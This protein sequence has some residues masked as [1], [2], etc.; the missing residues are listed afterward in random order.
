M[1]FANMS[2]NILHTLKLWCVAWPFIKSN[3]QFPTC[4]KQKI[5]LGQLSNVLSLSW[6]H[7]AP[8]QT[9]TMMAS[10]FV[11]SQFHP[12]RTHLCTQHMNLLAGTRVSQKIYISTTSHHNH[13][14]IGS[15]DFSYS[16][17]SFRDRSNLY[18]HCLRL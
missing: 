2:T 1:T 7:L 5:I 8:L 12:N 9:H 3:L 14:V 10:P 6:W 16:M 11:S 4:S 15:I 13:L 17:K 18:F